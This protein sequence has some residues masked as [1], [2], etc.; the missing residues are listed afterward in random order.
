MNDLMLS[1]CELMYLCIA[2]GAKKIHGI[3]D[4]LSHL[5]ENQV[6]S[7]VDNAV[8]SLIRKEY[9]DMDFNG[10]TVVSSKVNEF[11]KIISGCKK[12]LLLRRTIG[13]KHL[14]P[15]FFYSD[16]S[17]IL[18]SD[19]EKDQYRMQKITQEELKAELLSF[20]GTSFSESFESKYYN[21]P[22]KIFAQ[23]KQFASTENNKG[24]ILLAGNGMDNETAELIIEGFGG[25][26][27]FL[28]AVYSNVEQGYELTEG[29]V[30]VFDG[31]MAVDIKPHLVDEEE[32]VEIR[33]VSVSDEISKL[34]SVLK[35][36]GFVSERTGE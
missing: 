13:G 21:L 29:V 28:S 24:K 7:V 15:L 34:F 27:S 8:E 14:E 4:E 31:K 20:F 23:A 16:G 1:S 5:S 32:Y 18:R 22:M 11:I 33:K 3:S 17:N 10:N 25:K 36:F 12:T 2:A 6:A 30:F 9:I 35:S 26:H 19:F